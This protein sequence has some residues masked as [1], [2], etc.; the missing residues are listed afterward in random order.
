MILVKTR[1]GFVFGGYS[2]QS[3]GGHV[4]KVSSRA[5][6][7]SIVNPSG[8]APMKLPLTGY[9]DNKYAV[10]CG[11][12]YG[13]AFGIGNDLCIGDGSDT[14]NTSYA[15]LGHSYIL[16]PGQDSETFLAGS[17]NFLVAEMEVF[18]VST[19]TS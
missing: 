16:P 5:F 4:W 9:Q 2:D 18:A 7:F 10:Y 6:L 17:R 12:E 11:P 19:H 15:L 3:W 8:L 13:P 1:E 14:R